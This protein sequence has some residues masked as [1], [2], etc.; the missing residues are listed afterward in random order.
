MPAETWPPSQLVSLLSRTAPSLDPCG[1]TGHAYP[2]LYLD[3]KRAKEP[4]RKAH[5]G[6]APLVILEADPLHGWPVV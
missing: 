6:S 3:T 2:N 1:Q 5:S 4:Q